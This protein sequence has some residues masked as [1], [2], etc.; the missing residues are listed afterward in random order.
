MVS[1]FLPSRITANSETVKQDKDHCLTP[2]VTYLAP[3]YSPSMLVP[4]RSQP[5]TVITP[6]DYVQVISLCLLHFRS[7]SLSTRVTAF[8]TNS[9]NN[10]QT[11]LV[12]QALRIC[13]QMPGSRIRSLVQADPTCSEQWSLCTP[14][15]QGRVPCSPGFRMRGHCNEE[16]EH[17]N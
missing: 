12:V 10:E 8:S 13:L 4:S 7:I 6:R 17:N 5:Y 2:D 11:S 1:L 16:P 9:R 14:T 3:P 15:T